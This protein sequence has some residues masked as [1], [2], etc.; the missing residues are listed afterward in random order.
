MVVYLELSEWLR[1]FTSG[2]TGIELE[3]DDGTTAIDAVC[4]SG[5]PKEEVV[6]ITV[7]NSS[8]ADKWAMVNP[9]YIL[10]NRDTLK[11]YSPIIGG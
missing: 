11:V 8:E 6:F 3:V 1:K 7:L 4:K 5:V 9:E 2:K 10:K